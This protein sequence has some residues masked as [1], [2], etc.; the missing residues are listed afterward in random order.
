MKPYRISND[1]VPYFRHHLP[2]FTMDGVTTIELHWDVTSPLPN[3][4]R[5]DVAGMWQ[6]MI[7]ARIAGVDVHVLSPEDLLLHLC[8]H[9]AYGHRCNV[10][11]RASCD[12]AAV[13]Q[14]Y[15]IDWPRVV[16]RAVGWRVAAGTYIALRLAR[17]LLEAPVPSNVLASLEPANFDEN[18]LTAALREPVEVP[19]IAVV[20]YRMKRGFVRKIALVKERV[21]VSR[22]AIAD[23]Y[24]LGRSSFRVYAWYAVRAK[25]LFKRYWRAVL[26]RH[27]SDDVRA[28]MAEAEALDAML[29]SRPE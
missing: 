24:N 20:K 7:P 13:I 16:E 11:A 4:E 17:E 9:A 12:I 14:R 28:R 23:E 27:E 10:S 1:A 19:P 21:F 25:D 8:I 3:G 2:P 5:I 6:R 26:G 22:E 29:G 18:L 15:E